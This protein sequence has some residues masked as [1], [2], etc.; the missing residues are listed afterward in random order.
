VGVKVI[1]LRGRLNYLVRSFI[2]VV[3]FNANLFL[4][5]L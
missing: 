2:K 3:A 4:G 1:F 5:G